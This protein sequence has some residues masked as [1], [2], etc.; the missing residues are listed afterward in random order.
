M[1]SNRRTALAIIGGFVRPADHRPH[2]T[3]TSS[4]VL[5]RALAQNERY[6]ELDVFLDEPDHLEDQRVYEIPERRGLRVR[7]KW[8]L[9]RGPQ[10]YAVILAANGEQIGLAPWTLRPEHDWAPVAC[11]IG[12]THSPRQWRNLLVGLASG[13]IRATDGFIFKSENARQIFRTVWSQWRERFNFT[14]AFPDGSTVIGNAVDVDANQ[15]S[16][17]L[18]ADTRRRLKLGD[19]DVVFLAFSRLSWGTKGDPLALVSRWRDVATRCPRAR[20][21][22]S[23]TAVERHLPTELR[24]LARSAGVGDHVIVLENPYST[25]PDSRRRLMSAADVFVHLSTG[26]EEAAPMVVHE[27]FAHGLPVIATRWAGLPELVREGENG[28]L[29]DT[30]AVRVDPESSRSQFGLAEV[31]QALR[32]SRAVCCDWEQFLSY[33][34]ALQPTETRT[35]FGEAARRTAASRAPQKVVGE[36]ITFFDEVERS[37][38]THWAAT[39][40]DKRSIAAA[41]LI[42]LDLVLGGQGAQPLSEGRRFVLGGVER[43]SWLAVSVPGGEL[44]PDVVKALATLDPHQSFSLSQWVAFVRQHAQQTP[45]GSAAAMLA[46]LIDFGVMKWES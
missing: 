42:D 41:P 7:P 1:S 28:F 13:S 5:C 23:G 29:V 16:E 8:E 2:G 33:V 25:L 18:R 22:L 4:F 35:R 36:Y 44:P 9:A 43:I 40:G 14:P 32:A 10:A 46:R 17:R 21:I 38:R 3:W 27:A 15:R 37:A 26:M 30:H 39:G 12:T 19:D 24:A 34:V 11:S 20:L 45:P 6:S 31:T